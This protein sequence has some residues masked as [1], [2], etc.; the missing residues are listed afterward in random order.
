MAIRPQHDVE[1]PHSDSRP[2]ESDVHR[3]E[4]LDLINGLQDCFRDRRDVYV[5]GNLFLYYKKGDPRS[6]VAPDVFLV[7]GVANRQRKTYKLWEEGRVP[8][9]VIELTSDSTRHEDLERKMRLYQDLEIEE[10]FLHDPLGDYLEPPFQGYRLVRGRYRPIE[11]KP[12]GSLLSRATG[13]LFRPDGQ[14]LR[15]NFAGKDV[16]TVRETREKARIEEAARREAEARAQAAE[17]ELARL[18]AELARQQR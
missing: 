2:L 17:E 13:I 12:D 14:R 10:Y 16:L 6:V 5:A 4:M 1:Y 18:R 7:Q 9:L 8:S 3:D 11:P 15:L